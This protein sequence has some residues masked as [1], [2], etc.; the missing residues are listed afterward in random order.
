MRKYCLLLFLCLLFVGCKD[1][2]TTIS[3]DIEENE[4]VVNG[5]KVKL[6]YETN[7]YEMHYKENVAKF[8]SNTMGQQRI[9]SYRV[10][11]ETMMEIHI[12]RFPN[13]SVE[14]VMKNTEYQIINK[15]MNDLSYQYF[16]YQVNEQHGHTYVYNYQGN[17]Y[18]I[19][20]IFSKNIN[21]LEK[22]F[23]NNVTFKS[24]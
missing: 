19:N 7:F 2:L 5:E 11:D 16:E 22:L 20:F 12:V 10:K 14:E 21:S 13:K 17:T 23:M 4:V 8:T 1:N 15:R 9:I 24:E 3:T 6:S 18:T